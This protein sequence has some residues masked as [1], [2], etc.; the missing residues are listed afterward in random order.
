MPGPLGPGAAALSGRV[1]GPPLLACQ[2]C[3]QEN[4]ATHPRKLIRREVL[5]YQ[6]FAPYLSHIPATS[7]TGN[8]PRPGEYKYNFAAAGSEDSDDLG[9]RLGVIASFR[10]KIHRRVARH[11]RSGVLAIGLAYDEQRWRQDSQTLAAFDRLAWAMG[12]TDNVLA[13]S[14]ESWKSKSGRPG[15]LKDRE[16]T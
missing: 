13:M 9:S 14:A 12:R 8:M 7:C 6:A 1:I 2:R 3:C 16:K 4:V 10:I 5:I 11:W 15:R